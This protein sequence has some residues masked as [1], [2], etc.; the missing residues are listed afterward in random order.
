[1]S[2]GPQPP[3]GARI[4]QAD[5]NGKWVIFED[6]AGA[7]KIQ[8]DVNEAKNLAAGPLG[9]PRGTPTTGAFV[10]PDGKVTVV[11]GM[12]RLEEAKAGAQIPPDQGGVP[13]LP[14]WLEYDLWP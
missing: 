12:H 1:M 9:P 14:G 5:P 3:P 8:F 7:K 13:G 6:A 4:V 2:V 11:E 10:G